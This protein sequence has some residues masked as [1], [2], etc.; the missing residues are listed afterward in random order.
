MDGNKLETKENGFCGKHYDVQRLFYLVPHPRSRLDR[1]PGS[2]LWDNFPFLWYFSFLLYRRVVTHIVKYYDSFLWLS[3]MNYSLLF[4]VR[5]ASK[6]GSSKFPILRP[7]TK[8]L[9]NIPILWTRG[10][11]S[12]IFSLIIC[13][14]NEN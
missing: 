11:L 10:Y 14:R 6:S 12:K 2:G 9:M 1:K 8:C 13:I 5:D 4:F 3:I 7:P